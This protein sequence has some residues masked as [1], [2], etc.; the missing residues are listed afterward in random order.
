MKMKKIA[1]QVGK[2][3]TG[4]RFSLSQKIEEFSDILLF[5]TVAKIV[6]NGRKANRKFN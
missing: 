5:F 1:G 2:L 4:K 3:T 6:K